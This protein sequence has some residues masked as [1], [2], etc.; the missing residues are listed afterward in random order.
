MN[1]HTHTNYCDGK[2]E[3]IAYIQQAIELNWAFLGFSAHAPL[4]FKSPW[5]IRDNLVNAYLIELCALKTHYK[6]ELQ[7]AVGWELDFLEGK[8]LPALHDCRISESDF[9]ITSIHYLANPKP[10][11]NIGGYLE[12]DGDFNTFLGLLKL[13]EGDLQSLLNQYLNC[14]DTLLS[15]PNPHKKIIGHIDKISI[16]AEKTALFKPLKNWFYSQLISIIDRHNQSADNNIIEI[17][18]RSIY[19]LNSNIP[20]PA[21]EVLQYFHDVQR[22]CIISSDAHHPSELALGTAE[23]KALMQKQGLTIPLFNHHLEFML[24]K[25]SSDAK[26]I[27]ENP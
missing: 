7:I 18:T 27:I 5:A 26:F 20:Y 9:F 6:S 21:L 24:N 1:L 25:Q 13:Y 16:N 19:H 17:N 4:P 8:G 23:T 12:I 10:E 15:L 14:I 22:P 2:S 11:D 3:P